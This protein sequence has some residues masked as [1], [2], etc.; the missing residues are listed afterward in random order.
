M[1]FRDTSATPVHCGLA[2]LR[3]TQL[4]KIVVNDSRGSVEIIQ[5]FQSHLH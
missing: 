2:V 4:A 1:E 3:L 5:I